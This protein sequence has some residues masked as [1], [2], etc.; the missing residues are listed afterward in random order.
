V[1]DQPAKLL[2]LAVVGIV[3]AVGEHIGPDDDP[4]LHLGAE[5]FG[6]GG[7]VHVVQVA[8]LRRAVPVVHAVEARQVAGSF[9]RGKHVVGR[10]GGVRGSDTGPASAP[11]RP[12]ASM[13]ASTAR[14]TS[15]FRPSPKNSAGS[16]M[17][18]P[19]SGADSVAAA[20]TGF[21][22]AATKSSGGNSRLVESRRSK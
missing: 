10:D 22:L 2:R 7:H 5:A 1:R 17:R 15:G 4:P 18:R 9:R 21:A 3:V 11:G 16:P 13:P 8:V 19:A 6:A 14:R 20:V 12:S